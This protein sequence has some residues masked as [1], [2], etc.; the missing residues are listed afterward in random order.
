MSERDPVSHR[1]P[2][3]SRTPRDPVSHPLRGDTGEHAWEVPPAWDTPVP[4]EGDRI[5]RRVFRQ[6]D[7][8]LTPVQ[9][10]VSPRQEA[11]PTEGIFQ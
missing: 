4:R 10:G 11:E 5:T 3:V 8:R 7:G 6:V 2:A 1:V 9:I